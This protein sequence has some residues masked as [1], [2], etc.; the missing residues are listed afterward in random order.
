MFPPSNVK[1]FRLLFFGPP[2]LTFVLALTG[3]V[4]VSGVV[5]GLLSLPAG[6]GC[7]AI[8]ANRL[9]SSPVAQALLF[10]ILVQIGRAHV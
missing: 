7:G 10:I 4:E 1:A 3:L 8:L 2:V 6:V 9:A 5:S